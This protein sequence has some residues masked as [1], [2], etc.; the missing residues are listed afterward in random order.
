MIGRFEM[1]LLSGILALRH[2]G[3][4]CDFFESDEKMHAL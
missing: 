4:W 3:D 1:Y 2:V